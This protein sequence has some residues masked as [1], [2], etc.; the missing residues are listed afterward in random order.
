METNDALRDSSIIKKEKKNR[1]I[2]D[3]DILF[4]SFLSFTLL[5]KTH[6][7][8]EFD[9][10]AGEE[11]RGNKYLS[12]N[13]IRLSS[14]SWRWQEDTMYRLHPIILAGIRRQ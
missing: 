13:Q 9:R 4:L 10:E 14:Y 12:L 2:E 8:I 7:A 5:V 11:A 3:P 1:V 6:R